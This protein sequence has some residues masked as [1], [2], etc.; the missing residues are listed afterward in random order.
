MVTTLVSWRFPSGKARTV[1]INQERL[2]M[3]DR[4]GVNKFEGSLLT[5]NDK[6]FTGEQDRQNLEFSLKS[7]VGA[8][9]E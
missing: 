3:T 7:K 8:G 6:P 2:P 9:R 5:S 1:W 4:V